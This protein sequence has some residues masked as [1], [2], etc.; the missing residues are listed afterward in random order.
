MGAE[1]AKLELVPRASA[2]AIVASITAARQARCEKL[3]Q[4]VAETFEDVGGMWGL[5]RNDLHTEPK[6]PNPRLPRVD[7]S[8]LHPKP[9]PQPPEPHRLKSMLLSAQIK[10]A[11]LSRGHLRDEPGR[12]WRR[13]LR[14]TR[15]QLRV[16]L[17]VA[18]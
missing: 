14:V 16:S 7:S 9:N 2:K 10:R 12:Y 11:V 1:V 5:D 8:E 3:A 4:I 15:E 17:T 13:R 18:R 6:I